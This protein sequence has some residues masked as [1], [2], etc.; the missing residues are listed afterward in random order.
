MNAV[1]LTT[2]E[3]EP[4]RKAQH[5]IIWMH[6]LGADGNDFKPIVPEL[7]L[8]E[9]LGIRF[10]FPNAPVRSVT[11]NAGMQMRAWYDIYDIDLP[12]REDDAGVRESERLIQD[13]IRQENER[14]IATDRIVLAG[15]SQGGA[16]ALHT[17]LRYPETLAGIIALSCYVPLADTLAAERHGSN[18]TVP[19]LLTHGLLDP[20]IPVRYGQTAREQLSDLGYQPKWHDYPMGHEVC[21][22]EIMDIATWI[23]R[24]LAQ[25]RD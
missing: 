10:V 12:R 22:E 21:W 18:R 13:L 24:T 19:I 1:Q 3:I 8:P 6:G 4:Q 16:M 25:P 20:V 14:G 2:I 7:R 17:G 15:F 23:K 11:V 5:S 9:T